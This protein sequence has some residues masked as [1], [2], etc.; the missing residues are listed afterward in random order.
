[1]SNIACVHLY[2]RTVTNFYILHIF[3]YFPD[4]STMNIYYLEI[5]KKKKKTFVSLL[6]NTGFQN[7]GAKAIKL[8][9]SS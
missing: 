4:F 7:P 3:N 6:I 9:F 5:R 1:M 8:L 2:Y